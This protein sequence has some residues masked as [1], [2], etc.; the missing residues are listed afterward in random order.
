MATSKNAVAVRKQNAGA[1]TAWD[2]ELAKFAQEGA[3]Q[4]AVI[5]TG[6]FFSIKNNVLSFQGQALPGNQVDVVCVDHIHIK[7]YFEGAYNKDSSSSP[8]CFAYSRDGLAMVPHEKSSAKQNE[9]CDTCAHNVM[10]TALQGTGKRCRDGRRL[11]LIGADDLDAKSAKNK[12]LGYLE[13]PP[14]AIIPWAN[15]VKNLANVAKKPAFAVVTRIKLV[16]DADSSSFQFEMVEA[17]DREVIQALME[18]RQP[19]QQ[20]IIF[21]YAPPKPAANDK[22][23]GK[24]PAKTAAK[25]PA[26][27]K[28]KF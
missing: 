23:A 2:E 28:A 8:N 26:K 4:E 25:T 5:S 13:L 16:V 1:V 18:R 6:N 3:Q 24:A 22:P 10:G 17:L 12:Q 27:G 7:K 14:T 20:E 21:P 15:Y 11:A 9:D 19:V